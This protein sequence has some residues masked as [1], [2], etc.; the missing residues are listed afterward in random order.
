MNEAVP[1]S[2]VPCRMHESIEIDVE[3]HWGE[4]GHR[5]A[6]CKIFMTDDTS[7]VLDRDTWGFPKIGGAL[8]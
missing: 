2:Q 1:F 6:L 5:K 7:V 4:T 8:I 3:V